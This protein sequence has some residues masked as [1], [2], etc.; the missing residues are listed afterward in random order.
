MDLPS[1]A[2]LNLFEAYGGGWNDTPG[3][4]GDGYRYPHDSSAEH[5][6]RGLQG[7][8]FSPSF[9]RS[10]RLRQDSGS[11]QV[12]SLVSIDAPPPP[13]R[14]EESRRPE[15]PART[16]SS[17]P[18]NEPPVVYISSQPARPL[19]RQQDPDRLQ[20]PSYQT[21]VHPG[22]ASSGQPPPSQ[23]T[24]RRTQSHSATSY[25]RQSTTT[26]HSDEPTLVHEQLHPSDRPWIRS[27]SPMPGVP[28]QD[29]NEWR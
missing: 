9:P 15:R 4:P 11:S 10:D 16:S 27:P 22:Y 19:P 7:A 28:T 12:P 6:W 20:W 13:A 14:P 29:D 5:W 3:E 17:R 23:I 24:M 18:T 26:S 25:V 21:M 2:S 1:S 8:A